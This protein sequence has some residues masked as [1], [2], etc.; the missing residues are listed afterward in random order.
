[1][2]VFQYFP[3]TYEL[4]FVNDILF[5]KNVHFFSNTS[6]H[7]PGSYQHEK[8]D[9]WR[10]EPRR[11]TIWMRKNGHLLPITVQNLSLE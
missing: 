5:L 4:L 1:M 6:Q 10:R 3:F 8:T 11:F 2:Y 9:Q 7:H